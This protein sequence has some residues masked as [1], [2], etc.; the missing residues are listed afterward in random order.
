MKSHEGKRMEKRRLARARLVTTAL[1]SALALAVPGVASAYSS[2]GTRS[3]SPASSL[4]I[5]QNTS[6][7][8]NVSG[9]SSTAADVV[10]WSDVSWSDSLVN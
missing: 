2:Y 10:S 5:T 7:I 3:C 4:T 6:M 9:S 1:V 8:V